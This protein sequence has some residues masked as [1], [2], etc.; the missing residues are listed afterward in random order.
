MVSVR[1]TRIG[2]IDYLQVVEYHSNNQTIKVIK[3]FGKDNLEN[4][5][6]AEQFA[7][8]YDKL[9]TIA[10]QQASKN[11]N[12]QNGDDFWK[13]AFA[14]FGLVLGAAV[15]KAILDEIFGSNNK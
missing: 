8:D 15:V 14:V 12:N 1:T 3:S 10:Q 5:M 2:G 6:K 7:A 11:R 13:V 9:K 4:R